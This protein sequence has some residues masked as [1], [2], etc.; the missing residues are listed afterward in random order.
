[1]VKR[2]NWQYARKIA[3]TRKT[4]ITVFGFFKWFTSGGNGYLNYVKKTLIPNGARRNCQKAL[5]KVTP[6]MI[7]LNFLIF[8]FHYIFLCFI[9]I[10]T[11]YIFHAPGRVFRRVAQQL[12]INSQKMN[13]NKWCTIKYHTLVARL[14]RTGTAII[15][16]ARL[17][18]ARTI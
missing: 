13:K 3:Q 17:F 11:A 18:D 16:P 14:P 6:N 10:R 1:M 2:F 7:L 8:P 12:V 4:C 9:A 5:K 15:S